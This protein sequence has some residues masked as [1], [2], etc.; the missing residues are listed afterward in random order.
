MYLC[1][2]KDV[3]S[4]YKS[5][6]VTVVSCRYAGWQD[7]QQLRKDV[8]SIPPLGDISVSSLLK[9]LSCTVQANILC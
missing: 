6:A 1:T 8:S 4:F 3:L 2:D 5:F 9:I 7:L